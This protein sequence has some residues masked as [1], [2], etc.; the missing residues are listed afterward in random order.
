[1]PSLTLTEEDSGR[2]VVVQLGDAVYVSLE[3]NPTTGYGW[4]LASMTPGV[5]ELEEWSF[6]PTPGVAIGGGG[7]RR[8]SLHARAPGR[9]ELEL[10]LR[11]PWESDEPP[12]ARFTL[13]VHV[14]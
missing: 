5:L 4:V 2:E 10:Q 12:V 14:R 1:M 7:A 6:A 11:R 3:E 13:T 8:I 9:A